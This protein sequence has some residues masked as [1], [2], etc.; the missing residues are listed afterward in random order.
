MQIHSV[1]DISDAVT[2]GME[3]GGLVVKEED[4]SPIFFDLRSGLAGELL[5]KFVNYRVPLALVVK[6][7][8]SHGKRFEE[9]ARE[10]RT[11]AKVRIFPAH[12]AAA[13]WVETLRDTAGG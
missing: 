9:L 7:P 10:L 12:E 8:S 4:L 5:Q 2:K 1:R 13:A 6:D 3:E 11:H